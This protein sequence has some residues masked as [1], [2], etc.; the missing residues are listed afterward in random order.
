[1]SKF[2]TGEP[3]KGA[4]IRLLD[5]NGANAIELGKLNEKGSLVLKLPGIYEG[6]IDLQV[7]GGPGHRDYL[8]IPIKQ[9]Q[10]KINEIV[11]FKMLWTQVL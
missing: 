11:L 8:L 10:I 9:G 4:F 3:V 6:S 5:E 2:S 1:M 7:D